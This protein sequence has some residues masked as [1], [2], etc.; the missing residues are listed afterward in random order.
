MRSL[1]MNPVAPLAAA[2]VLAA[3]LTLLAVSPA[4][5]GGVVTDCTTFGPG[6]GTLATAV[7]TDG[8]VTFACSGT[9]VV[10]TEM[11]L[12]GR[13]LA[14]DGSG[15]TVILSGAK[16]NRL[17]NVGPGSSLQLHKVTLMA[18]NA[19][20]NGGGAISS[21]G[22]VTIT[23]SALLSN[24]AAYGGALEIYNGSVLIQNST[25][26]GNQALDPAQGGG[27]IDQYFAYGDGNNNP[28]ETPNVVIQNSTLATNYSVA[29]GRDGI[30][31]E[32][33][34]L[35]LRYSVIAN[36]GAGNCKI[37]APNRSIQFYS[38]GTLD[39][40]GTC[41]PAL[42]ADPVLLPLGNYGGNTPMFALQSNSPAID[43]AP[44]TACAGTVD[45]RSLLRP[46][47]GNR[48]GTAAC[49][50][51]AYEHGD[52]YMV[53]AANTDGLAGYWKFDE[54]DGAASMDSAGNSLTAWLQSGAGF[55]G[56][57]PALLFAAPNALQSTP[58]A[59]AQVG[60]APALNAVNELTVAAWVQLNS[61]AGTQPIMS[62]LAGGQDGPG[63]ALQ[64]R[65]G[66]LSAEAWDSLD[67]QH[68]IT[69]SI[70]TGTWLHVAMT[71]KTMGEMVAYI[72]GRKVGTQV[73]SDT[74]AASGAPLRMAVDGA[75]D[76]VRFYNRA[77]SA[78]AVAAL[79]GGRSCV[80]AGTTWADA[81]PDLQCAL[82][83][84]V[85]GNEVWMAPGVY[86]PTLGSDRSATFA[87][88]DGVGVYGGFAGGESRRDQRQPG[89]P[90][91]VL[92]GDIEANDRV[93]A[94]GV[95][96]ELTGIAGGNSLHVVTI[97]ST[98][99]TTVL[100][101][102]V[103]TGGQAD[104]AAQSGCVYT[105]GGGIYVTGGAPQLR[106]L[107]LVANYAGEQG[108]G[109]YANQSSA[110]LLALAMHGNQALHGGGVFFQ[111]ARPQIVNTLLAGNYAAGDGGGLYAS[112]SVVRMVNVTVAANRAGGSGGG[113][114]LGTGSSLANALVGGNFAA[115]GAQIAGSD[116]TV[117]YSLV[118]NGCG[119]GIACTDHVQTGEP[120]FVLAPDPA[121][122]PTSLGDFHVQ[123]TSQVIDQGN[124][125]AGFEPSL[126]EGTTI[127]AVAVDLGDV[128]RIIAARTKPAHIDQ[129]AYEAI[130]APPV[131]TTAPLT[132]GGIN[133]EYSYE[134]VAE[135]PNDPGVR[136]PIEVIMKPEW[137][138]FAM[139]PSG[140]GKLQG[141]PNT[142]WYGSYDVVLRAT[143]SLGAIGQ[144][145]FV[146]HVRF[147]THPVFMPQVLAKKKG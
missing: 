131:F 26:A 121:S 22:Y 8:L 118:Q 102:A 47:D 19:G 55:T 92:S 128:P 16:Q 129:G 127:S 89:T 142:Q 97:N 11:S 78:G 74:L 80:T 39:D 119:A 24:T 115:A 23:N 2:A 34:K 45:Q 98:R 125:D 137:L 146:L 122:A 94:G 69:S 106:S 132:E 58:A 141:T 104:G 52:R 138:A 36:N 27:A 43:A 7:E 3:I 38:T 61:T 30:W 113:L 107:R 88:A 5:A 96:T 71:Y 101:K 51:G 124:N 28:N 145:A 31:Q 112:N 35:Q 50:L 147:R 108:G 126:P 46:R 134:A 140:A 13:H 56:N 93:D 99:A 75:I 67:Q 103:V 116:T 91:P 57:H 83:E 139:Q 90:R 53:A 110:L 81:V 6:P 41:V 76:D 72:N 65:D 114:L 63:Y 33:G 62:K 123:P 117:Q 144:Q 14:L 21:A 18:G 84:A 100:E 111:D 29:T 32:N 17:F 42:Q 60:D 143:D 20:N 79:A 70:T 66:A 1:V 59:G 86:R 87:I 54:G 109:L 40:D 77:L 82:S 25:L 135:D 85:A 37:D 105:C 64:V 133:S 48:D 130:N 73:V 120:L 12:P 9:I 49:D 4:V 68:V 10:T 136:L 15:Q 95:I 44:A